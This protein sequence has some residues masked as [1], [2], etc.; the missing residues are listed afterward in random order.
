[1]ARKTA[2]RRRVKKPQT[3][4]PESYDLHLYISGATERSRSAIDNIKAI[5]EKHLKGRYHLSVVDL[6]QQPE[7]AR[8]AQIVV[9]PTL[10]KTLPLPFRQLIGDLSDEESVL[11]G[12]DIVPRPVGKAGST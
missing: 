6:Y 2:S 9:A 8:S 1:M 4:R 11:I 12:L 5:G 10:V 7:K 3:V